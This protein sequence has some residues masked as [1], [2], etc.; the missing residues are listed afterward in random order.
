[1]RNAA[2]LVTALLLSAGLCD[3]ALLRA[4]AADLSP[5]TIHVSARSTL[6]ADPGTILSLGLR[7]EASDQYGTLIEELELPDEWT[8]LV[9]VSTFTPSQHGILRLLAIAIPGHAPAGNY[10]VRYSLQ[11]EDG[12]HYLASV[13]F[14]VTIA[15]HQSLQLVSTELPDVVI[16]GN[17]L[18]TTVIARNLGNIPLE[19]RLTADP[20]LEG[21]TSTLDPP[22]LRMPPGGSMPITLRV[23]TSRAE[24]IAQSLNITIDARHTDQPKAAPLASVI[25]STTVLPVRTAAD[26]LQLTLPAKWE[27]KLTGDDDELALQTEIRGSGALTETG[28][29]ELE[30]LLRLPDTLG[31]TPWGD[32]DEY[33]LKFRN[34]DVT[35]RAGDGIY[36]LSTL[37]TGQV[38]GRGGSV[39][40]HPDEDDT[41]TIGGFYAEGRNR[42]KSNSTALYLREAVAPE[43]DLQ[44]NLT[45]IDEG[46]FE[47]GTTARLISVQAKGRDEHFRVDTEYARGERTGDGK[48]W[49][50]AYRTDIRG[51]W[52]GSELSFQSSHADPD[53]PGPI[54]DSSYTRIAGTIPLSE[55]TSLTTSY[56]TYAQNLDRSTDKTSALREERF[57]SALRFELPADWFLAL[58]YESFDRHDALPPT[59]FDTNEEIGTLKLGQNLSRLTWNVE[60]RAGVFADALASTE[61][62]GSNL[63]F[64]LGWNPDDTQRYMLHGGYSDAEN[65]RLLSAGSNFLGA[66]W[67][68]KLSSSWAL[69]LGYVGYNIDSDRPRRDE[70]QLA[71]EYFLDDGSVWSLAVHL[72]E[73][74]GRDLN[75]PFRMSYTMPFDVPVGTRKSM[76]TVEGRIVD[77]THAEQPG[78]PDVIL[79]LGAVAAVTDE[80]GRFR[81]PPLTPGDYLLDIDLTSLGLS[82]ITATAMPLPVLIKGGERTQ[83]ELTV[84][85]AA[86]LR[87][88]LQLV[89]SGTATEQA[90]ETLFALEHT[91]APLSLGNIYLELTQGDQII[92]RVTN[93]LGEFA[94]ER[95]RPGSWKL[96][97]YG[98]NLPRG[99]QLAQST[100]DI[101]LTDGEQSELL[102]ELLPRRREIQ[103]Q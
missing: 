68:Q 24:L 48:P 18:Q 3:G 62:T 31:D 14:P 98:T 83:L 81:F 101:E 34:T 90:G 56:G 73:G 87:G 23:Q 38:R 26:N 85:P 21:Y 63:R 79:T 4:E 75:V 93:E 96:V 57:R 7:V 92:R 36:S 78:I 51:T 37:T 32:Q 28:D 40:W 19:L 11:S 39:D 45:S 44:L 15:A 42:T 49:Q 70:G 43:V 55:D 61:E 46:G 72:Q 25:V 94:F 99:F 1:M 52:Q 89:T 86:A 5:V 35:L 67:Q 9:P 50:E 10:A 33:F 97:V 58:G 66:A 95:L 74:G 20:R 64:N 53:Y 59:S 22:T 41:T 65:A 80:D 88:A 6:E 12:A 71:S 100:Y 84:T 8:T 17:T 103:M 30:F 47:P 77:I 29:T 91:D 27:V 13:E 76:G 54:A 69:R 82:Q 102:I 2:L 16:A 60:L